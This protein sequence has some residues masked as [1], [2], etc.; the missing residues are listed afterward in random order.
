[1]ELDAR[2][3]ALALIVFG[4]FTTA[5]ATGFGSIVIALAV[6]LHLYPIHELLPVLVL[7]DT[8]LNGYLVWRHH[9]A[10]A[11]SWLLGSVLPLLA[12][13]MVIGAAAFHHLPARVLQIA[14]GVLVTVVAAR[15]LIRRWRTP[16]PVLDPLATP[17]RVLGLVGAGIVHGA[18][19]SGGPLLVYVLGRSPLDK[20]AFRSTLAMLWLLTNGALLVVYSVSGTLA[21]ASVSA[22][23]TLLPII[24]AAIVAGQWLHD[25]LDEAQ[26]RVGVFGMLLVIGMTLVM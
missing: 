8:V 14:F 23:V 2:L 9:R 6:G 4:S 3:A 11:W 12:L 22:V 25:R 13:G 16:G 1:M 19:A 21:G 17:A 18:F 24:A 20:G 7:L 5:A 10:I 15:E 26:F